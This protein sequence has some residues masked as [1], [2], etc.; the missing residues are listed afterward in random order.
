MHVDIDIAENKKKTLRFLSIFILHEMSKQ[1]ASAI[2][3][4]NS[5]FDELNRNI[6]NINDIAA[7]SVTRSD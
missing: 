4:Q 3:E 5:I 1:N 6:V 7:P 2:E